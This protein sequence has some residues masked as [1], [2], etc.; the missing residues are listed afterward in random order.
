MNFEI[1]FHP[2]GEG[3]KAG[4]AISVRYGTEGNYKVMIVDGGTDDSGERIVEH[5]KSVYGP[6]TIISDVVNTHPDSDHACGL[7]EVVR[8]LPVE[9]LWVHGLWHHAAAITELFG[10]ARWTA[11][12]LAKTI[13]S[14]YPVISELFELAAENNVP[15]YEPFSGSKIGPFTVLTPNKATY[16]HLIPQFRKT[17]DPDVELLKQRGIWLG[18]KKGIVA[19]I[20]EKAFE[21]A[22]SWI[23]DSWD[24]EALKEGG[25]TAAENESSVVLFGDF[26][27]DRVL[28]T[29]DAGVNA[30]SW[31]CQNAKALGLDVS[32]AELIQVPHHGS[33]RNVSPS[34]LD[35]LVG[36]K[37]AKGVAGTKRAIVS[38]PKDDAKHPRKM[39]LNAFLRRGAPVSSTQGSLCRYSSGMPT[40]AGMTQ[41][42]V[43]GFF[44]KVVA[45]D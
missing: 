32:A 8:K 28:L 40:R 34:V 45:Y 13:R 39:V 17:P 7:R 20:L 16:Q 10:D 22:T 12:G 3:E 44:D 4:D 37:L 15:I 26:G 6:D 23:P 5:V 1:E 43:F 25:V 21:K 9:R 18:A 27:S 38:A 30:L 35:Q 14:E 33:R 19:A 29:G 11:D 2:V 42:K 31:A 36:P 41:A 24:Y